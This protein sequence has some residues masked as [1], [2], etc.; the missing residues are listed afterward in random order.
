MSIKERIEAIKEKRRKF[1][2]PKIEEKLQFLD[3]LENQINEISSLSEDIKVQCNKKMGPY[4]NMMIND[5]TIEMRLNQVSTHEALNLLRETRNEYIRLKK[6]FS[7]QSIS[8][9]VF[10]MAGNGKSQF[11]QS[12]TGLSND[13]VLA[14]Q[15]NHVTGVSSFI[16]NS[17]HFET[18]VYLYTKAEIL[19]IFNKSLIY[20]AEKANVR[21]FT[22]KLNDF[23]AIRT[24]NL[25]NTQIPTT[26]QERYCVLKYVENFNLLNNLISGK[27]ENGNL[28]DGVQFDA[29]GRC[30]VVINNPSEVQ[31]WVAQHNG[32]FESDPK[33]IQYKRYLAVHH[34]DIYK[35]FVFDD[36]GDIVL[37]DTVGLGDI[38]SDVSTVE[39]MYQSIAD[40]S[41]AVL[42]LYRPG[43]NSA[44]R[45][46]ISGVN[47]RIEK[48][49][50]VDNFRRNERTDVNELYVILNEIQ[51][52][53]ED[54]S[55]DCPEVIKEFQKEDS[56]ARKESIFIANAA[57]KNSVRVNAVE[58]ILVQLTENLEKIDSRKV[59]TANSLG[60]ELYI[61]Y[62]TLAKV[63]AGVVS[64]SMKH[65]S[66]ELKTFREL[67]HNTLDY[68]NQLRVL[69]TYYGDKKNKPC[70]EVKDNIEKVIGNLTGLISKPD[71]II[72]DVE[73]GCASTN[74]IFEKYVKLFR[75]SIYEAFSDLNVNILIPLQNKVIDSIIKILFVNAKMGMIPLQNY[76]VED[77]PSQKWLSCFIAEKVD[78][79]EY[80]KMFKMLHFV[81]DYR[82]NI[83]GL[84]E[85]NVAKCL[86]TVDEHN[87]EFRTMHPITGVSDLVHAKKIW[88]EIIN[89][90]VSI[91]TKMREWRDD[92]SLIPSHSFYA[93]VS[94]FRDM[95][96]KDST[97]EEELYNFYSENRM[98]IWRDEFASMVQEAEAFG[99][100]NNVSLK[101][102]ELCK[103]NDF[104]IELNK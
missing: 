92:F 84:I 39:H 42:M 74:D 63:V 50:Y 47:E 8:L 32:H 25:A 46:E 83:Q 55:K 104:V 48:I 30:Y 26:Q 94:M 6:R 27:D 10:G 11:I 56:Y 23:N 87:E 82:L 67:Y 29:T 57:D 43:A 70:K 44:W 81:L 7:R 19:D 20:L 5:P 13:V 14:A 35:N 90:T 33:Y 37:M 102:T 58:P 101:T 59:E 51:V 89:R 98:A 36:A 66:N 72:K 3:K 16:Y 9:Q 22:E 69:D 73:K 49:R 1:F 68:S 86:D 52:A 34:V 99:N 21:D 61:A 79:E 12:V 4:Y 60:Q 80:P 65:G 75:I 91:Q 103:K 64:G 78:E 62:Q 88:S 100:W 76:A 96:V 53:N 97:V 31:Q 40:N 77:G 85:F 18:R 15:G 28:L 93:R 17:D 71:E 45:G 95:M 2:L 41:D 54:N 24:F 38:N